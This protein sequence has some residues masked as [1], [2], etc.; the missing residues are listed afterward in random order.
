[1]S[2]ILKIQTSFLESVEKKD[3]LWLLF[4]IDTTLQETLDY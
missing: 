3:F 1:M 4:G 2:Q